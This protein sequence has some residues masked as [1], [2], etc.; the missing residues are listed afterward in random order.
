[1]AWTTL[2][3]QYHAKLNEFRDQ[4][5]V[6]Q[7]PFNLSSIEKYQKAAIHLDSETKGRF[8]TFV[9]RKLLCEQPDLT[10]TITADICETCGVR[11]VVIANDSKLACSRCTKTRDIT[12]VS[13]WAMDADFSQTNANQKSRLVEWLENAQAKEFG[14]ISPDVLKQIMTTLVANR[15]TGLENYISVIAEERA[16]RPFTDAS[17]AITRLGPKIPNFERLL[18]NIDSIALRNCIRYT[19]MKKH[20]EHSAKMSSTMSGFWPVRLTADQEE[21]VRKLFMAASPIYDRWRKTSQPIWPG[22]YAYF[23]RCL[24]ILLGWDEFAALFPIQ[25][26]GKNPERE[27]MRETIWA[28]LQWENVP[29]SGPLR[30]IKLLNGQ[31]LDG[32][33]I[34]E[35][36]A[37]CKITARGYDD[38]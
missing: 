15:A 5:D 17:D 9:K 36:D 22:G 3:D 27:D 16:I 34:T 13:A 10:S 26:T 25:L 2:K 28:T 32:T 38:F 6:P 29:S 33:S 4:H 18:K 14:E 31:I 19:S 7:K 8:N 23:L 21:Y 12:R 30:P 35:S 24:M 11:M 1:M 20:A 37:R